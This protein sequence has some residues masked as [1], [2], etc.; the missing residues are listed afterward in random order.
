MWKFVR[1][2]RK[3]GAKNAV[4]ITREALQ[5]QRFFITQNGDFPYPSR[6]ARSF[7][8]ATESLESRKGISSEDRR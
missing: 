1:K 3:L 6:I 8:D 7:R 4:Q 2:V 5:K